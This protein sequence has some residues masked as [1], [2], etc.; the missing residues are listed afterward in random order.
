MVFAHQVLALDFD[1]LWFGALTAVNLQTASF[2][3]PAGKSA[4]DLRAVFLQGDHSAIGHGMRDFMLLQLLAL[5]LVMIF[6][7]IALWFP[8]WL[9]G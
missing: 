3:L 8:R 5:V 6:P 2:S 7:D 1:R 9:F 4:H